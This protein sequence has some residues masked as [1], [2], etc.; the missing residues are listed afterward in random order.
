MK[1][2][3]YNNLLPPLN[4]QKAIKEY[5]I[6]KYLEQGEYV[7][8]Y[9]CLD[10]NLKR[11]CIIKEI[12]SKVKNKF[13]DNNHLQG[14]DKSSVK[15]GLHYNNELVS[16][17]TFGKR[18]ITGGK[19]QY[20]L[21]RF[22]NK[23]NTNILGGASKLLNYFIKKYTPSRL[24]SYADNTWSNGN[25][26][27]KLKFEKKYTSKPDYGYIVNNKRVHKQN[28]TKKK[29]NIGKHTTEESFMKEKSI[30]KIWDCGKIKFEK[31]L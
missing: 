23:L 9:L 22:C 25:L 8:T 29:L 26:Y 7:T 28:F 31:I 3:P 17:M 21:I 10:K 16:V 19:S 14:R 12:D 6:L 1:K 5:K 13:L 20:E 11:N 2:N 30:Y 4:H 18:K 24:I 27:L 15:L